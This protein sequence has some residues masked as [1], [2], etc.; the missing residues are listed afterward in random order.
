MKGKFARSMRTEQAFQEGAL[1]RQYLKRHVS[2]NNTKTTPQ[3]HKASLYTKMLIELYDTEW[4]KE[5]MN[6]RNMSPFRMLP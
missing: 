3:E 5:H 6:P 1:K 4:K 2:L